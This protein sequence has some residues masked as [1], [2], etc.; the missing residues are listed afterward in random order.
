M[1]SASRLHVVYIAGTGRS[2][3]TLLSRLLGACDGFVNI[4]EGTAY[5]FN[6][7]MLS[8]DLPCGCGENVKSCV[9]WAPL[10]ALVPDDV[11][12]FSTSR[13]RM[14]HFLPLLLPLRFGAGRARMHALEASVRTLLGAVAE[15]SGSHIIIDASKN[16]AVGFL[17]GRLKDVDLH[18]IHLVRDPR[19]VVRSW[20]ISKAYLAGWPMRTVVRWWWLTNL[21]SE[22]LRLRSKDYHLV[23]YED[24]VRQP[25][26]VLASIASAIGTEGCVGVVGDDGRAEL[27]KQHSLAGNP[28]KVQEGS[29]VI[30]SGE[31]QSNTLRDKLVLWLTW[32]LSLRYGYGR[33]GKE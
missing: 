5:L 33:L 15:R 9:F 32:P 23:L 17:L 25:A 14:R 8:R 20:S 18:V 28:D 19:A 24:L 2:G 30:R 12:A 1:T 6:D 3:S 27:G 26:S 16:P 11:R 31:R 21:L 10:V 13:V 22:L 29:I 7:H 4:G